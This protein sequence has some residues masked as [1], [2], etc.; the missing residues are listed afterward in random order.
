MDSKVNYALVGFFVIVIG[1]AALIM[2][3]WL[4]TRHHNKVYHPYLVYAVGG[5]TGLN[6][7]SQ[8]EYNGVRVGFVDKIDLD[9]LNPQLVKLLLQI[10]DGTPVLK[11]TT[12]TLVPQGIT[13][14]VN[15]SLRSNT[16]NA[17]KLQKLSGNMYPVIPY[18][19][20]VLTQLT[21][22]LPQLSMNLQ[23]IAKRIQYLLNDKNI[24]NANDI[25]SQLNHLTLTLDQ[26]GDNFKELI[27]NTSIASKE[28]STTLQSARQTADSLNL[29]VTD[30]REQLLPSFQEFL[31]KL[32]DTTTNFQQVS[33]DLKNNPAILLRGKQPAPLG[34]GE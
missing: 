6:V 2:F 14:L 33:A 5:V 23:E 20:P 29:G 4:S 25:L 19:K 17:P 16:P 9:T 24:K 1:A 18:E 32:N 12:A 31:N 27:K 13:G 15:V 21:E 8:V 28:F 11:S 26:Q 22:V 7:E 30:L 34:P 3:F 10:E